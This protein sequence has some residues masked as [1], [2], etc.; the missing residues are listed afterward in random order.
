M[1]LNWFEALI[2]VCNKSDA[3][4]VDHDLHDYNSPRFTSAVYIYRQIDDYFYAMNIE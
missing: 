1:A 4:I 3:I 2:V